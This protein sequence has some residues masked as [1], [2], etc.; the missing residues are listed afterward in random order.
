MFFNDRHAVKTLKH[1]GSILMNLNHEKIVRVFDL[2]TDC[3]TPYIDMEL[4]EGKTLSEYLAEQDEG[5]LSEEETRE[6]GERIAEGIAYAHSKGVIHRDL[7]PQNIIIKE[8]GE[9]KIAD[10][11]ISEVVRNTMTRIGSQTT[12]GTL[13]YMS[14]EQLSGEDIG[15]EADVYSLGAMMYEMLSGNPPFYRG[16]I[17]SQVMNKA[18]ESIKNVSEE[19]NSI[20]LT[21]LS[22]DYKDR[23]RNGETLLKTLRGEVPPAGKTEAQEEVKPFK[24]TTLTN[25]LNN[26]M[27]DSINQLQSLTASTKEKKWDPLK[28]KLV[29]RKWFL[30]I[31]SILIIGGLSA[32]PIAD[33]IIYF[34][35]GIS[36]TIWYFIFAGG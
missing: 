21:C 10:F 2:N 3:N 30:I 25:N 31:T 1:E 6:V 19:L 17:Y 11:G 16:D 8:D 23:Y 28:R 32:I 20:I 9:V 14:P 7:K 26:L 5:T 24:A 22:K 27:V 12:S 4:V 34:S 33:E 29:T 15:F 35:L 13:L 36:A 18:A